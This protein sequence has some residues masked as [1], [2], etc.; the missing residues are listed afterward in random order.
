MGT[1]VMVHAVNVYGHIRMKKTNMEKYG[2][3]EI[4]HTIIPMKVQ[5]AAPDIGPEDSGT[6]L[7]IRQAE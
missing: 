1:A 5:A 6:S 3:K 7:F 4:M 2:V